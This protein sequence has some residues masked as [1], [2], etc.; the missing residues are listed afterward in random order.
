VVY[1]AAAAEALMLL[2]RFC[3]LSGQGVP[4][5][6][7]LC[8]CQAGLQHFRGWRMFWQHVVCCDRDCLFAL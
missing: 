1:T 8:G 3:C 4:A 5:V 7:E 6:K 2:C